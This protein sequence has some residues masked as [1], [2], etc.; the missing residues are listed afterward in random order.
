MLR[1]TQGPL[2]FL[3]DDK[4]I[5]VAPFPKHILILPED[6]LSEHV[7]HFYALRENNTF[8]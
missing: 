7:L 2:D 6:N 4:L 5:S 8:L 3:E 1:P